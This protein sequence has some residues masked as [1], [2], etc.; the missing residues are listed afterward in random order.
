MTEQQPASSDTRHCPSCGCRGIL[1]LAQQR[2]PGGVFQDPLLLCPVCEIEFVAAGW[3]AGF[4]KPP[5]DWP[6]LS[7]DEKDEA[8]EMMAA[9]LYPDGFPESE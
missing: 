9:Q 3:K 4:V 2:E 5:P 8:A 1:P 7:D 6:S